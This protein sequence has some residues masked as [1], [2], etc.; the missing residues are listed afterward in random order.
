MSFEG[1]RRE[2]MERYE[3]LARESFERK[4]GVRAIPVCIPEQRLYL[5]LGTLKKILEEE[6]GSE[7][8]PPVKGFKIGEILW[9]GP[10]FGLDIED[11]TY[12]QFHVKEDI[13]EIARCVPSPRPYVESQLIRSMLHEYGHHR[14]LHRRYQ[15]DVD[16]YLKDYWDDPWSFEG[17]AD[18]TMYKLSK[19]YEGRIWEEIKEIR[20]WP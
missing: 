9:R 8:I 1:I 19:K 18:D 14:Q 20:V 11:Y 12:A 15:G 16:A 4:V 5:I 13:L 2:L 7:G 3:K 17:D 6:A 10:L